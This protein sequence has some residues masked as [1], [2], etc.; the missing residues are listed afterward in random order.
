VKDP[1]LKGLSLPAAERIDAAYGV[2][3]AL[4]ADFLAAFKGKEPAIY[5]NPLSGPAIHIPS[6]PSAFAEGSPVLAW[7]RAHPKTR[8]GILINY[9]EPSWPAGADRKAAYANLKSLGDRFVGYVSGEAI[10]HN[11]PLDEAELERRVRAAHNRTEILAALREIHTAGVVRK[12]SDMYGAPVDAAEAW[13]PVISCLSS[14]MEAYSHALMA[15]GERRVGHENTGNSPTLARRLAFL[16]GAARQ[17]GGGFVDY[18]SCNLGD[19]SMTLA[20]SDYFY[21]ASSQYILDNSY[22]AWAGSGVNWVLKDALLYHLAGA[23]ALYH[24]EGHDLFWKPGGGAAG[25][26]F[27]V[28]LSPRGRVTEAVQ[29]LVSEHPR[30]TQL[31][32]V[33]FLLDP[34]H[35]W[36]QERFQPGGF[37]LDPQ[38][39]P[40][41]LTPGR[42]E[43]SIR[44]WFDVAYYPAPETQSEPAS[45]IR[46]TFVNGV[47]GDILDV[48]VAEP[49][50]AAPIDAYPVVI[51]AGEVPLSADWGKQLRAHLERG[52]TLI[53]TADQLSGPGLADLDLPKLGEI[54]EASGFRWTPTGENLASGVYRYRALTPGKD[55]V[56]ATTPDGAPVCVLHPVGK[57]RIILVAASLGLGIDERPVPLLGVLVRYV[58]QGLLPIRAV[59]DVEWQVNRLSDGGWLV[60]LFNNRGVIKPQ[61]GVLAVDHAEAQKVTL[62]AVAAPGASTEWVTD[63]A[64]SWNGATAEVIVPAGSV[65]LIEIHPGRK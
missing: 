52:A 23:D 62:R 34:A 45:A 24:E 14:G 30:G 48:L 17:F 51:A 27:P 55:R 7:L 60:A 58:T 31:T 43:A 38:W 56:L 20:R 26:K 19:A 33:A 29:K 25:D 5:S 63:K 36:A 41:V 47:F 37:G 54:R 4:Q 15:W 2:D 3:S 10:I 22:D 1:W 46:Q 13:G 8:F 35:G 18:Q 49:K 16:R 50:H 11:A 59:G 28:Q 65:R 53:A 21:P 6:Y 9:G 44:G 12:F 64:V 40:A 39:N 57:G 32:P 61:H 42:H